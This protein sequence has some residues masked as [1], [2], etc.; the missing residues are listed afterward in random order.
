VNR[1][2]RALLLDTP[3]VFASIAVG[4]V[5]IWSSRTFALA[6]ITLLLLFLILS[7]IATKYRHEEKKEKGV[8]EHERG[9]HNVI[10]NGVVPMLCCTGF[11]LTG[12]PAWIAAYVTSVAGALSDKFGSELGVLSG[13]PIALKNLKN[14]KAGTSG[15]IS[16]LGTFLSFSGALI[17]GLAAYFLY[18]IDPSV[19]FYIAVGGF[20]G[21]VFDT[22]AGIF[23]EMGMGNKSTSNLICTLSSALI[24]F[25]FI[26]F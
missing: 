24:G 7:V 1:L 3:G 2:V 15:A 4:L 16:A 26:K 20:L 18:R 25:Y 10:S 5:V 21:G 14:V 19:I 8:Y 17:I 23:E 6:N 22:I 12:S 11:Y 9:L 13:K